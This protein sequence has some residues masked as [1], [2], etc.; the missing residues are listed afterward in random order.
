MKQAGVP[1]I[2][3]TATELSSLTLAITAGRS[4]EGENTIV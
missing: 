1:G 4:A 2:A 3:S